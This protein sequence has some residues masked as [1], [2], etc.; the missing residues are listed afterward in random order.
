MKVFIS[1]DMEGISGIVDGTMTSRSQ[2]DY[3]QGRALMVADVNAAIEG[4]LANGPAEITVCEG[5]G[6]MTNMLPEELNGDAI[7]VRG[8]NKPLSQM[9]GI[10]SSYDAALF[11]G[12][13]SKK[14]T[15]KGTLS[16]TY[17]GRV[18]ESLTVNGQEIGETGMNGAIAGYYGVPL[19]FVAGDLAVCNEAK[20]LIPGIEVAVVKEAVSRVSAK[21]LP[22]SKA[23]ALITENVTKALHRID[24]I[25]PFTFKPPIEVFVRFT[26]ANYADAAEF[27]PSSERV[28]GKTIRIVTDDYLKAF[29][30]FITAVYCAQ[31]VA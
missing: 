24:E 23:R 12:Y 21:C 17:S 13:H 26:N 27:M 11:V 2:Q 1:V 9:S 7:L 22:P 14:G 29:G 8:G 10:D 19:V 5:H 31:A 25:E 20:E 3:G 30:G 6:S 28:D 15:L 16:H 18:I 4:V